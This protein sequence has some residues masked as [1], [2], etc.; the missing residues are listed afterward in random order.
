MSTLYLQE[1]F[2]FAMGLCMVYNRFF[3]FNL[4]SHSILPGHIYKSSTKGLL[5]ENDVKYWENVSQGDIF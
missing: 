3:V 4:F 1:I 5:N 2:Y